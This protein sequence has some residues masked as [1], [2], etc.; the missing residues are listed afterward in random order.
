[1]LP[2]GTKVESA[3]LSLVLETSV[4]LL[5]D[6][7][8]ATVEINR[9]AVDSINL[10]EFAENY[11]SLWE[12]EVPVE[13]LHTDGSLNQLSIITAQRSILGECADIDNPAN[14]IV[15]SDESVLEITM[16]HEGPVNLNDLYACLFNRAELG[17]LVNSG[18]IFDGKNLNAEFAGALS[19]ASAIGANNPY[20]DIERMALNPDQTGDG[21]SGVFV[22]SA[23]A[24]DPEIPSLKKGE[25]YISITTGEDMIVRAAGGEKEGLKAA[26]RTIS[27]AGRLSQFSTE[28]TVI[29]SMPEPVDNGLHARD[30]GK[31]LLE[32]FGYTDMSLAGAFH[33]QTTFTV[34]EPD[35]LLGG[36]GSYFEV[37]FNH[38][39]ALLSDASLLTV[40]F[41]RVPA[42]SIQ[43]SRTNAENGRLRVAIPQKVLERG[44]FEIGID[45]YNY[46]GRI[47]CSKDW[48]DVAWT[49]INADSVLYF[50]PSDI[51]VIP[52]LSRF[53]T[54]WGN[55]I[56][57]GLPN[58][59]SNTVK[60]ALLMIAA[61]NGQNTQ[62]VAEYKVTV[63]IHSGAL[64][65]KDII[66]AGPRNEIN[67]PDIVSDLLYVV[68]QGNGYSVKAGVSVMPEALSDKIILQTVRSPYDYTKTVIVIMWPDAS[69]EDLL[70]AKMSDKETF[71][72]LKEHLA[73]LSESG[74]VTVA[75]AAE[76]ES[77]IP[78]SPEV[79]VNRVVRKTGIPKI[80]LAIILVLIVFLVI[81][82]IRA[83]RKKDRFENAR[84]KMSKTNQSQPKPAPAP[85]PAPDDG[86]DDDEEA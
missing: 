19:I 48:S 16:L 82:I 55:N 37:H 70:L 49:V 38:S 65:G 73:L 9:T 30:N 71:S 26:V 34:R 52:S 83:S 45:V 50:E 27:D 66:I 14:W 75:A 18:F 3:S 77:A 22:L 29:K 68:P 41:D 61:K 31:Y 53:P 11:G 59:T 39:N 5:E 46:L 4:T 56:V 17:S 25:G 23:D 2:N 15:I 69:Y 79:I 44:V 36:P 7:S 12:I 76:A 43:L 51:T 57:L 78:L 47:D 1:M 58:D 85:T 64:S 35:G 21:L 80:G 86:D 62:T 54:L 10:V 8:T 32:D 74:I 24:A 33:Q 63:D 28:E 13:L 84:E 20:K 72:Q 60:E 67:I 40:R 42:A 6:Y 81:M